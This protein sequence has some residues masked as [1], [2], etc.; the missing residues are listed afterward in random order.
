[1]ELHV[2][3]LTLRVAGLSERDSARLARLVAEGLA[4]AA[5]PGAPIALD[6]L[7][8][9]V[10]LRP[11]ETLATTAHRIAAEILHAIARTS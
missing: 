9:S 7:R 11:G 8:V 2:D 4:A 10:T 6:Q 5:A 1:M 3:R